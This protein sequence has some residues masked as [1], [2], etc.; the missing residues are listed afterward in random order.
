MMQK[1][2]LAL[3]ILTLFLVVGCK[4]QDSTTETPEYTYN[5]ELDHA[6]PYLVLGEGN[7]ANEEKDRTVGLWFIVSPDATGYEEYAET[8]IQAVRDLYRLY[9]RDFT[10]VHLI[11]NDKLEYA[12]DY[13]QASYAADG[14]GALGMTGDAPAKEM[15]WRVQATDQPLTEQELAIAELWWEKMPDFPSKDPLSSL[16]Y[17][18]E[19]LTQYVADTLNIPVSEVIFPQVSY[20]DYEY[21][22]RL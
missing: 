13:A 18:K 6:K 21:E 5:T 16:S 10:S 7:I 15:Y 12:V 2:T 11:P 4:T 3:I 8:A 17:D 1:V 14:K 22:E 20:S 9:G 19:A